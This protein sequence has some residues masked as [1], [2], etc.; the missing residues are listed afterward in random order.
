MPLGGVGEIGSNMI[1]IKSQH[2]DLIIDCGLLFPYEEAFDIN[3]LIPDFATLDPERT[4]NIIITP[5]ESEKALMFKMVNERNNLLLNSKVETLLILDAKSYKNEFNK[6]YFKL[7]LETDFINFFPLTWTV[8]HKIDEK[9]PL[10]QLSLFE[11][12]QRN[13]E[14]VVLVESFDETFGQ[15]V[16]S[17]HSFGGDQ[18]R[19]NVKFSRNYSSNDEGQVILMVDE[20][21]NLEKA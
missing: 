10:Y 18:W 12:K 2:E 21:D 1:L 14:V 17:R 13:A 16:F 8:V 6:Q 9:S 11:M 4:K 5:F 15:T 3:Y 19:E 7:K 20:I